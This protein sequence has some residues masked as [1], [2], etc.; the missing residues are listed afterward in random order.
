MNSKEN[1][2]EPTDSEIID[3][4]D[5]NETFPG[6]RAEYLEQAQPEDYDEYDDYD[7]DDMF[8]ADSALGSAGFGTDEY[9]E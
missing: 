5:D 8:D 4:N 3:W 7:H 1:E 6:D 2:I 9:Y